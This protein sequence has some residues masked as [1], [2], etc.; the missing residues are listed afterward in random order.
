MA[1]ETYRKKRDFKKTP[2][3][4][5]KKGHAKSGNSFVIQK[6]AARR[7]H[8]DFRLELDGVLLSWA[9]PKGPSLDPKEKRLAV[10]VEDHPI[11]YGKFEGIIP[12][13]QYGAGSVLLWDRGTWMPKEDARKSYAQGRLKFDLHGQKLHGG[14]TLVR[15]GKQQESKENWLLIKERDEHA[16][17]GVEAEIV[18]REVESVE[19]GYTVEQISADPKRAWKGTKSR[20]LKS[21]PEGRTAALPKKI[22]PQ[23]AT[24]VKEVPRGDDWLHEIKYDGYRIL[25]RVSDGKVRLLS[26]NGLDW[27]RRFQAVADAAKKLPVKNGWFDGEVVVQK[28]D[29]STSFQALQNALTEGREVELTYYLFDVPYCNGQDLRASPLIERKKLLAKLANGKGQIRYSDHVEGN[30]EAFFSQACSHELEGII[31]KQRDSKYHAART[32]DW[33]KVK[34][35]RRQEFVIGGYTDPSGSRKGLGALLLGVHDKTGA[36]RYSGKVGT[37]FNERSLTELKSRLEKIEQQSSP[38]SNPPRERGVHWVKPELIAEVAFTEWTNENLIRHSSFQGLREDKSA[39]EIEEEKPSEERE[40]GGR[41]GVSRGRANKSLVSSSHRGKPVSRSSKGLDSGPGLLP[42]GAGPRGNDASE[43][44]PKVKLTNPDKVLYQE[45]GLTKRD[46]A[47]YYEAVADLILPHVKNR[48]L[49]LVRCP[50]GP[51][52]QCFYQKNIN[53]SVPEAIESVPIPDQDGT[54]HYMMA[55]S[56]AALIG[57][58]QMGVLEIHPW[59]ATADDL[60]LPDRMFF[61]LDPDVGLGFEKVI[62]AARLLHARLADLGLISFLK[63]TGGKGLHVVVPLE[64]RHSWDEMKSF[65]KALAEDI[66]R[67]APRSYTSKMPKAQRK[68]KIFIDYLRNSK[69]QTAVAAFSTRAKPGA[70]VSVPLDWK[71]LKTGL[72]PDQWNVLNLGERLQ[73]LRKDP[74]QDFFDVRQAITGK[75]KRELGYS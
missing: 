75:M 28:P 50:N 6:H 17:S 62:E 68:G 41:Q 20:K 43:I 30:G 46:L 14:W 60:D 73:R 56:L 11:E 13:N 59:G 16:R 39:K 2:E 40:A 7:L 21:V 54:S 51:K 55:N 72:K 19:S 29:G 25:C 58:V 31:S 69:G 4:P 35:G 22:K 9:V 34:C 12:E 67:Q 71:E 53:E 48:P 37:G 65:S 44:S 64:R 33:V 70:T 36:L 26:R 18:D 49:T 5:G 45:Q 74:W 24:L 38:F 3:P 61:D 10:H 42:A 27:T 47:L 8:Y 32:R 23:L 57:L 15:M 1:L 52:A 63:T 66:V